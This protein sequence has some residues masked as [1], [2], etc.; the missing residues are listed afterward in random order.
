M[1][2]DF[3]RKKKGNCEIGGLCISWV[4]FQVRGSLEGPAPSSCRYLLFSWGKGK[5]RSNKKF[6][7]KLIKGKEHGGQ[8]KKSYEGGYAGAIHQNLLPE[9]EGG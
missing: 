5:K 7:P 2:G 9:R 1:P 4:C 3:A 8:K 6:A